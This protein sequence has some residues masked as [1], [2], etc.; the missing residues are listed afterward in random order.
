MWTHHPV[1][2]GTVKRPQAGAVVQCRRVGRWIDMDLSLERFRLCF[3]DLAQAVNQP[4]A[5]VRTFKLIPMQTGNERDPLDRFLP[6]RRERLFDNIQRR[7]Q[8]T[9]AR[10]KG[11]GFQDRLRLNRFRLSVR[12]FLFFLFRF[13]VHGIDFPF[14]GI[15]VDPKVLGGG[16]LVAPVFLE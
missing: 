1:H 5:Q 12:R 15:S 4:V 11:L 13:D 9:A 8:G 2:V 3:L 16:N 14:E 10:D 7:A 6:V